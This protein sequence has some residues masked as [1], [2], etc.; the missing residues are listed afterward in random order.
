MVA[1]CALTAGLAA[2]GPA[3]AETFC[4]HSPTG[5]V[6]TTKTTLQLALDAAA[7]NGSSKDTIQMGVGLFNDAPAVNAAGSPVDIVGEAS[8]KT[9]ITSSS[10][11]ALTL[12]TIDEPT[13]TV[14]QFRVH[15][16][17]GPNS[18]GIALA[19]QADDVL[20]TNQGVNQTDGIRM[21][22]TARVTNSS[23]SLFSP[24]NLQNRA[25]FAPSGSDLR[26][27]DSFLDATVGVS[28]TTATLTVSRTRIRATQGV[29]AS[30]GAPVIVRDSAIR[31][32]GTYA[33]NFQVAALS[34]AGNNT[35]Q[36]T[37]L[38]VS[39]VN[40]GPT[41]NGAWAV[42]NGGAQSTILVKGSV[43]AG[44]ATVANEQGA[45]ATVT[46]QG[47]SA[48]DFDKTPAGVAEAGT[49][50]NLSGI[51]P[52]INADDSSLPLFFDSPLRE[53]GDPATNG[54]LAFD[55]DF[56]PRIRDGDGVA[57]GTVDI[58][59]FEYQRLA[60]VAAATSSPAS[61]EVGTQFTFDGGS[62]TDGDKTDTL[63][64]AW[65]FDDGST[66]SGQT[67][68]H[69]FAAPGDHVATLTVTDPT[70]LTGSA[71]VAVGVTAVPGSG[72][73][74]GGSGNAGGP[75]TPSAGNPTAPQ[76]GPPVLS[77]LSLKA[78]VLTFTLS[79]PADVAFA[80][81]R[82]VPGRRVGKACKKPTKRNR[83]RKHCARWVTRGAFGRSGLGGTNAT[84][85]D[86]TLKGKALRPGVYRL[87]ARARDAT[88]AQSRVVRARF[89]VVKA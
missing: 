54:F 10:A 13:S 4:V 31:T 34:A 80:V 79:E 58:G 81:Q 61:A 26:V 27:T 6:G 25:I 16:K 62:S 71:A 38:R 41:G 35:T 52:R 28:A 18:T 77:K 88:G 84:S 68:M 82:R 46:M 74:G 19:G 85:W 3:A 43:F 87:V 33:S 40:E 1:L 42:P 56:A 11:A 37:A 51:D 5:C 23:V 66:A 55:V 69:A 65:A 45:G 76:H 22:G 53:K 86:R 73:P 47:Y 48:Y 21:T 29:V 24:A 17:N 57:P 75:G 9:A 78:R 30:A 8:N 72:T 12:L 7:A 67:V 70:G 32:P 59:A 83:A 2:A 49:D 36:L 44:Y 64:Y 50:V 20:V 60:P 14:K 89:R 63:T 39:A 15:V